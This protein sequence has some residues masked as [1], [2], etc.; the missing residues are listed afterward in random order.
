MAENH[1]P[2]LTVAASTTTALARAENE[3]PPALDRVLP[4]NPNRKLHQV[5]RFF[6]NRKATLGLTILLIFVALALLAPVLVP[7]DPMEFIDRPH[8]KPSA[9]HLFGTTGQGQDV[10][11]QVIW[12]A[13]KTMIVA[14][15]VG[16]AT[17]LFGTAL[18]MAA[19]YFGG[20]IDEALSLI[21]NLFLIIP[22]LPLMVVLAAFM[23]P[24]PA[25][26][27]FVLTLTGW[28]WPAR[29]V[30]SQT[31]SLREKDFVSAAVVSGERSSRIIFAEIL[32]N[33]TSLVT[34]GLIGST[35]Y[36]LGASIALEFLGLGNVSQA[37]WGVIL[38][39][40]QNNAALLTGAWWTF[41][42]VGLCMAL[43]AFALALLNYSI[44]KISNPRLRAASEVSHAVQKLFN[45]NQHSTPV[46]RSARQ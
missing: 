31:L 41:V 44:D 24:G 14:F 9:E 2:H 28:A 20:S 5:R 38:F 30:R 45:Q 42:P 21:I 7:G 37:S 40:A 16:L 11:A 43:L 36:A 3:G 26:M 46:V 35:T 13:R 22:G 39:W 19:G 6:R 10:F 27:I 32:P 15:A 29:V 4:I 17:T 23:R 33:M 18:G 25:T 1:T 34:S 12:G 8:L